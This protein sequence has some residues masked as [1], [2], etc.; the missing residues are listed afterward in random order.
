[1]K[2]IA[3]LET[4]RRTQRATDEAAKGRTRWHARCN[5]YKGGCE[6]SSNSGRCGCRDFYTATENGV[7]EACAR[8]CKL[9]A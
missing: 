1:M 4:E 5:C 3:E 8:N 7:C 2:T 6:H 9:T